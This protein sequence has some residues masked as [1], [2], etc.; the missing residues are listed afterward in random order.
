VDI[1]VSDRGT[2][3]AERLDRVSSLEKGKRRE[4]EKK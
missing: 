3:A 4:K 1:T 2:L